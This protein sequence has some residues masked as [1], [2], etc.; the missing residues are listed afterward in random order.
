MIEPYT[1]QNRRPLVV[2]A[3]AADQDE[4][5]L[6][7]LFMI[8]WRGKWL[9]AAVAVVTTLIVGTV[10]FMLPRK[11]EAVVLMSP[12]SSNSQQVGGLSSILSQYSGIA[13][14]AGISLSG[15][16]RKTESLALLQSTALTERYIREN[17]LLPVL[18]AKQWDPVQKAWK[19]EGDAKAPTYWQATERFKKDIRSVSQERKTGLVTLTVTWTD[20][21]IA[22]EWANGLVQMTN[23]YSRSKAIQESER[24][25]AF[26]NEQAAKSNVIEARRAIFSVLESE[27]NKAM[28]A[29]GN[30]EF[31]LKVIDPAVAPERPTSP[32]RKLWVVAGF[33]AGV[34]LG[35]LIV[36]IRH[37]V[38]RYS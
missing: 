27:I 24:N 25:I 17:N 10:A 23:E 30:P 22:A 26:L 16:D 3:A 37:S 14:L 31:A 5:N 13:S 21:V 8:F 36:L 4:I 12:A 1:D 19:L 35:S 33:M 15:D 18:Y 11:Y 38:R 20:P 28:L 34:L 6:V 32:Q 7:E 9:I 29:R 2:A